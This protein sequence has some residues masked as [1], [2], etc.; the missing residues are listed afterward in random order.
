MSTK[1]MTITEIPLGSPALKEFVKFPWELYRKDPF[2]TPPLNGDLLGNSLLGLKGL[3]TPR[4]AYHKH[5]EVIH[6][7][8]WKGKQPVGR[9]SAAVN[10]FYNE[11]H[12]TFMGF[13]GFLTTSK[14]SV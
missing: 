14:T 10:K 1:E 6:F 3:L 5:A 4:H 12:S 2:W 9:I 11:Y 8:A 7:M 13:F